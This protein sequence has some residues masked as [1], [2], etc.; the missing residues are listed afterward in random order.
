MGAKKHE[1]KQLFE[2][3]DQEEDGEVYLREVT[4]FLR[5]LNQDV[6]SN[7]QVKVLLDQ[8]D[9]NGEDVLT[10]SKFCDIMR[11]LEEAGW[12]KAAEKKKEDI[13]ETD[14]KAIFNLVDV[15]KSGSLSRKE[16]NMAC[17]LLQKRFG[18]VNV[19]EWMK[20]VDGDSDGKL[21]YEEFAG[22]IME[23]L[24]GA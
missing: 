3:I 2:K 20:E 16:G 1:Y 18:I 9:S 12:K 7:L 15:D 8:Y 6:D 19:S 22:S 13:T 4:W 21:D 10:F 14:I 17:K 24:S 11:E 5:A 23:I